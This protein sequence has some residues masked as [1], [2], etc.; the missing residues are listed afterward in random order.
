GRT[1]LLQ[2]GQRRSPAGPGNLDRVADRRRWPQTAAAAPSA[3][4]RERREG[5]VAGTAR[6]DGPVLRAWADG[7]V[8]AL[9]T[10]RA[11]LDAL[12]V[13][14]VADSDTGT[15]LWLTVREG[16]TGLAAG[17]ERGEPARGFA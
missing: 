7:A 10:Y 2:R 5:P 15:N 1:G 9:D 13:F 17:I 11:E 8:Q 3:R 4:A 12:N 16:R 14:P 6:L